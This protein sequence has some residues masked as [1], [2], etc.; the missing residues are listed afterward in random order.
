MSIYFEW[1]TAK[2]TSNLIKHGISF[3]E[4]CST[5]ADEKSFTIDDP[6]HST[7]EVR[8]ILLGQSSQKRIL[9]IAHTH[10]G[11]KLRIISARLASKKERTLYEKG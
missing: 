7:E 4:A 8:L 3:D 6:I 9:V 5:F 11:T 2:A 10:R 1:D